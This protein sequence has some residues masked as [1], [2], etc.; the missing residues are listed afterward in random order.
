MELAVAGLFRAK[1]TTEIHDEWIRS[2]LKN[3]QD[4]TEVQLH[5]TRD[6]MNAAVLDCLVEGYEELVPALKLPDPND[7]HVLAAA[8]KSGADAI[9]TFNRRDF[10]KAVLENYDIELQHPDTFIQHQMGLDSARVVI[11]AQRCRAR[12]KNPPATVEEYLE[13][14]EAQSLPLTVA[15]L[16]PYSALI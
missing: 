9:I 10:P 7:R 16:R 11:A 12:L 15:E 5:R 13:R 8:I 3:R 6:L 1:W 2:V 14:L 4:L